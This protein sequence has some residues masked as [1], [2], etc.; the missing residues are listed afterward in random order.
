MLIFLFLILPTFGQALFQNLPPAFDSA[1]GKWAFY[2]YQ[3][4]DVAVLEGTFNR[5]AFDAPCEAEVSDEG[6]ARANVFLNQTDF[7]A[8]DE[9]FFEIIGPKAHVKH[10][11][12]LAYQTHEAPCYNPNTKELHFTE[13]GP[14]GGQEGVHA[15]Q[16]LLNTKT[17]NLRNITTSPPTINAHGCVFYRDDLYVVTDGGPNETGSLVKVDPVTLKKTVLLNNYYQ[18]PF[19]GFNDLDI[20]PEGN[21]WLTDS[22][23]GAG[24]DITPFTPPTNPTVYMV[25]GTTMR[26]KAVHV[27]TGNANGVAVRSIDGK[28]VVYLPD[29]GVSKFKPVSLKDPYGDRGLFAYDAK[30]GGTLANR[31]LLNNP[32]SYFYDGIRVSRN[33][34][35][36]VGAGDGVDVIDPETGLALGSIRVGG[37]DN[38][39]VSVA[40]GEHELWIVGRGGVW[41]VS[42]I[43]DRPP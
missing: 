36:F 29:T 23:S 11:Q 35:V 2:S 6:L 14:P 31:R 1:S 25:N 32:I 34:W 33:G 43:R 20:D 15:W 21:F 3:D 10:I 13:W 7:V 4:A 41:H 16:Y 37:G 18:Q 26:P 9:R 22:K 38:L 12:H 8:Y 42:G 19:M 40:F 39:A 28:T 5:S 17:N 30:K 27:T 24:R